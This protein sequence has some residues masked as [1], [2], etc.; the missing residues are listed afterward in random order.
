MHDLAATPVIQPKKRTISLTSLIIVPLKQHL[1]CCVIVPLLLKT[2]GSIGL[3][4]SLL[5][6]SE[7]SHIYLALG[8]APLIV[9]LCLQLEDK[10]HHWQHQRGHFAVVCHKPVHQTDCSTCAPCPVNHSNAGFWR[11][12]AVNLAI[13]VI[14]VMVIE[15]FHHHQY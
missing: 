6:L 12:Y 5:A 9:W 2:V 3:L 11:R 1:G 10:F 4:T 8:L 7:R 13:A 14:V 15:H